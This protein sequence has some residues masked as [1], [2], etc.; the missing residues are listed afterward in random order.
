MR[1]QVKGSHRRQKPR[2][3]SISCSLSLSV[4][5]VFLVLKTNAFN[6]TTTAVPFHLILLLSFC[7][8]GKLILYNLLKDPDVKLRHSEGG[9]EREYSVKS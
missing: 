6:L 7:P 1:W 2:Y 8:K 3:L 5:F 4:T 9:R